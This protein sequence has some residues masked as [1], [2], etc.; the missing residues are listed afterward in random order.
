[1]GLHV[2]QEITAEILIE[3]VWSYA[4]KIRSGEIKAGKKQKW[5]V[6]RFLKMLTGSQKMTV[7]ITL[8]LKLL[9]IFMNGRGNLIMSKVYLQGSRLN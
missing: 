7:L 8:M 4:G 1:M 3:R 5:A 2:M 9:W 6:E